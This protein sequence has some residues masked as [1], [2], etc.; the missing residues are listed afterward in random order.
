[1]A[2]K[3]NKPDNVISENRKARHNYDILDTV[4]GGLMLTGTEVKALREGKGDISEAY[5]VFKGDE[6]FLM[7]ANIAEYS[8]GNQLNHEPRR[9]RKILLHKKEII[10]LRMQREREQVT[11]VPLRLYWVRGKVKVLL[12][13]A[14]G[15]KKQDKRQALKEKDWQRSRARLLKN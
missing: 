7:N 1:M 10:E 11:I 15:R 12:A 5:G 6:M 3:P 13:V 9:T 8:H 14:K 2:K 4:E